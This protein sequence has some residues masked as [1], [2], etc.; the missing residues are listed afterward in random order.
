MSHVT[1]DRDVCMGAG[2]CEMIS[3]SNFKV[4][5]GVVNVVDDAVGSGEE[6][7]VEEAVDACPTQALKLLLESS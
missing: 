7:I 3:P 6:T 1:A 2:L 4:E 5:D